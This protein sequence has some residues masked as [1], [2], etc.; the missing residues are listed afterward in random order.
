MS[1]DGL[2]T[3]KDLPCKWLITGG[4]GYI[5]SHI[6]H[7]LISAG[8]KVVVLDNLT[9]G[10]KNYVP[11]NADFIDGDVR[12][13]EALLQSMDGCCGVIHLA[14]Y[15]YAAES[16]KFPLENYSTNI[17]GTI[18]LLEAMR[19][20]GVNRL[21][22]SSTAGVYGAP[23]N[24]PVRETD[25]CNPETP[26]SKSKLISEEIIKTVVAAGSTE[27]PLKAVVL[28]YFNVVGS[29]DNEIADTSPFNLFP[30]ILRE[31]KDG[32]KPKITGSDF[33]TNDGSAVRDYIH[34]KDIVSAHRGVIE[35]F[36]DL[37]S[38]FDVFNLSTGLGI[39]VL[40]IMREFRNQLGPRFDY[41][42]TERRPGDSAILFGDSSKAKSSFGW[43][44]QYQLS[45]MVKSA[46]TAAKIEIA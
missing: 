36:S 17:T 28:R 13:R 42:L 40:Q 45:D 44:A 35:S 37:Q 5:G 27:F 38:N 46:V 11:E 30:I 4:A 43:T 2:S 12:N 14:G 25:S 20:S 26:Y 1:D 33:P 15:K 23:L 10:L 29:G 34:I 21:I 7:D 19:N 9:T 41:E 32:K 16:T 22:Y 31:Y 3:D 18:S 6:A 24:L 8:M 39:S